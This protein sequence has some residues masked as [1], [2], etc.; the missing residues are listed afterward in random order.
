MQRTRSISLICLCGAALGCGGMAQ[1]GVVG[2]HDGGAWGGPTEPP[3][4][5]TRW[6]GVTST[7][8]GRETTVWLPVDEVCG[9]TERAD[10]LEAFDAP[11]FRDGALVGGT[12][13]AVDATHLWALDVADPQRAA[14]RALVT[15][16]GQPLGVAAYGDRLLLAAGAAGLVIADV[17]D[18]A[19]PVRED[20]VALPGP[21]LA[22]AVDGDTAYVAAGAAGIAVVALQPAPLLAGTLGAGGFAAAVAVRDGRAYVARCDGLAILDLT[23]GVTLGATWI[24]GA[25]DG[26]RLIAPAKGVALVGDVAFV[27]AGRFGAVAVDVSDPTAPVV[28]GNC[29]EAT[30]ESFYA[31]GLRAGADRLFVAG[32]EWG[33]AAIPLG[34]P[35]TVCATMVVPQQ[36]TTAGTADAGCST[37]P[38]WDVLPWQESWAPPPPPPRGRDPIQVLVASDVVYAFG[39]ARRV[40]VRAVEIRDGRTDDLA[41]L[42]RYEEPYLVADLSARGGRVLAVG[43]GGGLF[44]RD[45]QALLVRAASSP[46]EARSGAVTALRDTNRA[47]DRNL[48]EALWLRGQPCTG[49][50]PATRPVRALHS[51]D[52]RGAA[53]TVI[54]STGGADEA[55]VSN[56]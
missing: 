6:E 40:G 12:L 47:L 19:A 1:S 32:G 38:P 46:P 26:A 14:R 20:A 10:Y 31:S 24:D 41:H 55:R 3:P 2:A 9:G 37:A 13:F 33:V 51:A 28:L 15:G 8:C 43:A 18:P 25:W 30:D 36:P 53:S 4:T 35:L 56:C 48:P 49:P 27:A 42:G 39:D 45:A 17:S 7:S 23:T 29:T 11:M 50:P 34:D 16:L 22:V 21:A 5:G 52:R 44:E 54:G